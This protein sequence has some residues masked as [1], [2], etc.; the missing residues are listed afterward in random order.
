VEIVEIHHNRNLD[1]PRAT[2]IM[3]ADAVKEV[4]PKAKQ[5]AGG[6]ATM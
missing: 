4:R 6:R 2:A 1:A 3:L 5:S